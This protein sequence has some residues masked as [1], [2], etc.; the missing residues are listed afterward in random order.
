MVN[1]ILVPLDGSPLAECVLP[2]TVAMAQT[3]GAKVTLLQAL[4]HSGDPIE[5]RAVDP[6]NWHMLK[7]EAVS[8]LN[9]VRSRLEEIDL[10]TDQVIV[11]GKAAERIIDYAHQANVDLL[12]LSSHGKSGLSKWNISNVV[13]KVLLGAYTPT[14]IVRAFQPVVEGLAGLSYD[15]LLVP[16]DGSQRAESVLPWARQMA[17]F[18]ESKLLLTHVVSKPEV[19][20]RVPLTEEESTLVNRL[21]ELN[22]MHGEQ[23]LKNVKTRFSS[24]V[25]TFIRVNHNTAAAL[26]E[27]VAEEDVDLVLLTA[28]GYS[29]EVK[30]PYG[31]VVL[32]FIAYGTTPL[33]IFQDVP[34]EDASMTMTEKVAREQKGH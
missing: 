16:L 7:S 6:L 11:E 1:H 8:Y 22:K 34:P 4:E 23:Y 29:G 13:Q 18:H 5:T 10:Q 17:D 26:H 2:H 3:T 15:R 9:E 21:T 12:I 20:R 14:L 25:E 28:H 31:G 19:P 30:W 32:N 24:E 27:I 33:L